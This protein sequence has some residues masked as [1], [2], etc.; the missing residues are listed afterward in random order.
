MMW[1][2]ST[3]V[4]EYR[5]LWG[6]LGFALLVRLW[7]IDYGLPFVYWTDE[8]HEVMRAMELGAGGFNL[9]RTGK[10]GFYFLL[11]VEYG[12]YFVVLKLGGVVDS[13]RQFA[14]LFVKDPSVFY[15]LG[16]TT[17]A[18]FGA[19]TVAF[20][21][22]LGR[23]AYDWRVGLAAAAF[24]AVNVLHAD[25]SHRVGVD[26]PM[27]LFATMAL[28]YGV[29]IAESGG[30]RNYVLAGLCAGLATTT[31]LP[32]IAVLLPLLVAHGYNAARTGNSPKQWALSGNVWIAFAIF[33]F[34]WV[35][36]NPGVLFTGDF[37]SVYVSAD[38]S[39]GL[40]EVAGEG[41]PLAPGRPNLWWFYVAVLRESMGWPLFILALTG[42]GYAAWKRG[43]AD[44]MLLVYGLA[45]FVAIAGTVS[46][47]LYYP[48]YTLPII[49]CLSV[50][51]ARFALAI[52]GGERRWGGPVALTVVVL[53]GCALPLVATLKHS[54]S[55]TR[56]DTRTLAK[57]WLDANLPPGAKVL[58][59]G[60]KIAPSRL[61]VQ[62][63]DSRESLDRRIEYWK[64]VE[65]RQ[66]RF[67]QVR[68]GVHEGG[69]YDLELV[70]A[71]NIL[72]VDDYLRAGVDYFV[73]RP[74][75]FS[76]ARKAGDRSVRFL[77]SLRSDERIELIARFGADDD[78]RQGPP[79]EVYRVQG[80][81]EQEG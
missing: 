39:A 41:A 15:L 10:G 71:E 3:A 47:D 67:L 56:P 14:E 34:V 27:T 17:A 29:R 5:I 58:I 1:T 37:L 16:R 6:L 30:R 43:P 32:G 35:G 80:S 18:V 76:G 72:E 62:L 55:L 59:E 4:L 78:L 61:T 70:R 25:L 81:S 8:Y 66:A 2:D 45:N 42:V 36:T 38:A 69:G 60:G 11:F 26:V 50:L 33:L 24:L 63:Q 31:K 52:A 51:A 12:I 9:E 49:V 79:I 75:T 44:I 20:V 22:R 40:E 73:I 46:G 68:R 28:F 19:A 65:P 13:T 64:G 74:D 7:G 23:N 48:R 57:D 53:A 77:Q 21:Y 54:Y